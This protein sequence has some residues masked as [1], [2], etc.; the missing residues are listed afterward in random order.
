LAGPLRKVLHGW[1]LRAAAAAGTVVHWSASL[2]G[3]GGAAAVTVGVSMIVHGVFRQVP[4]LGAAA[5]VAGVFGLL[6]DRR[7]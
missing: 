5:L 1:S 6:A 7:L 3:I 2:P 4:E